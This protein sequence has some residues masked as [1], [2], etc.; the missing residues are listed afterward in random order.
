MQTAYPKLQR[1]KAFRDEAAA[2]AGETLAQTT[3]ARSELAEEKQR[4]REQA[5]TFQRMIRLVQCFGATLLLTFVSYA[6]A[7]T[8]ALQRDNESLRVELRLV[9]S[10]ILFG[11][12]RCCVLKN[13]GRRASTRTRR[14]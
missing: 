6:R 9:R 3:K 14:G 4:G 8:S 13:T 12:N 2:I 7:S 1:A 10:K 11:C 5:R